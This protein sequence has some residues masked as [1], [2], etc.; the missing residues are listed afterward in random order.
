[1][2]TETQFKA[3]A[4][5]L[6]CDV[7]TIKAVTEVESRGAG[8]LPNGK[9][10]ILFEPHIFWQELVRAGLNP[11]NY[12]KGNEDILYKNWQRGKY[13]TE[14]Q[15]WARLERAK[16]IHKQAALNSASYGLFQIMGFNAKACTYTSAEAMII[17]YEKGEDKQLVGFCN[18]ITKSGLLDELKAHDWAGFAR[19][20]NGAGYKGSPF[21]TNDD[22]DLKLAAAYKKYS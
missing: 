11:N 4:I 2:I 5:T 10:K 12:T 20:Y 13:G 16:A 17:D 14:S 3:A 19:Q 15:Q 7:A 6:G 1:M 22:Y 9:L 18:Y 21:T 8:F